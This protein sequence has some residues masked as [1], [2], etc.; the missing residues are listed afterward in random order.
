MGFFIFVPMQF[1]AARRTIEYVIYTNW[2]ISIAAVA[3]GISTDLLLGKNITD[4]TTEYLVLF[5]GTSAVYNFHSLSKAGKSSERSL[6]KWVDMNRLVIVRLL[7]LN[8]IILLLLAFFISFEQLILLS[9]LVL[10]SFF[11]SIEFKIAGRSISLRK[12]P[13]LKLFMIAYAWS[14]ATVI[15]SAW[16]AAGMSELLPLFSERLLLILALA[17]PFDIRDIKEDIKEGVA[18]LPAILGVKNAKLI[19]LLVLCFYL[20]NAFLNSSLNFPAH[21]LTSFMAAFFILLSAPNRRQKF[22]SIGVDGVMI[23]HLAFILW[24]GEKI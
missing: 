19:A 18:T 23:L 4:I 11:Y 20:Y 7:I 16:P 3:L 24:M 2:I 15:F 17:I 6:D 9:H 13:F 22:F 14:V 1:P 21:I 12:L 10:L 8:I 5:F